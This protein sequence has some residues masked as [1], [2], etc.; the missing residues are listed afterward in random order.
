MALIFHTPTALYDKKYPKQ[1]IKI[2]CRSKT[3]NNI[4]SY[5]NRQKYLKLLVGFHYWRSGL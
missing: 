3:K 1:N 2:D 4:I 5:N